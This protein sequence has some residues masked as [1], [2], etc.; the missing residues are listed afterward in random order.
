MS[1][2]LSE[3]ERAADEGRVSRNVSRSGRFVS[4]KYSQ[5]TTFSRDWDFITLTARGHVWD[6]QTGRCVAAPFDKFFNRGELSPSL[7]GTML[8]DEVLQHFVS[9]WSPE[10]LA[11]ATPW[12][13]LDGSMG[14]IWLD[15]TGAV[16]V[17]TPGSFA[18]DQAL[19][20]QEWLRQN[21]EIETRIREVLSLGL[22]HSL[23]VEIIYWGN[24]VVVPY[25]KERYGL[26]LTGAT[27]DPH[28]Y[29]SEA[30]SGGYAS[31]GTDR[32]YNGRE[33]LWGRWAS[34]AAL[35]ALAGHLGLSCARIYEESAD[36]LVKLAATEGGTG[37]ACEGWVFQ[38]PTG[39]RVKVK[40]SDYVALHRVVTN[41]HPNRVQDILEVEGCWGEV[42]P[43]CEGEAGERWE[44]ACV[45]LR[46]WLLYI[47]E[48]YREP[49]ERLVEGVIAGVVERAEAVSRTVQNAHRIGL[50]TAGDFGR[51]V[52]QGTMTCP[53]G[54]SVGQVCRVLR[55]GVV[56]VS[57]K[58]VF[59]ELK[60][61]IFRGAE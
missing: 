61:R 24:K 39:A 28:E 25:Q 47:D 17:N 26:H 36:E 38:L 22:W 55:D 52:S 35:E 14:V 27:M 40:C 49:Y 48:E 2:M 10:Q 53:K 30:T 33:G 21:E 42:R 5:Q 29:W 8:R 57:S 37:D 58:E 31:V 43:L 7:E 3:Y 15:D 23:C 51:A 19:W 60:A 4:F 32:A 20:A 16:R 46:D 34:P 1:F 6:R 44:A 12:E 56:G 41:V 50:H 59:E 18:S 54:V 13:K 9:R 11:S 45:A